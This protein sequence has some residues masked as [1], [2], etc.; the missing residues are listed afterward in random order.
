[1][2]AMYEKAEKADIKITL[3]DGKVI[4]GNAFVTRP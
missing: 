1:M 3:K 4:D 2:N